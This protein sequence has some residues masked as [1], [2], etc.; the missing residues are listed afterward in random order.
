[1]RSHSTA[2]SAPTA[3]RRTVTLGAVLAVLVLAQNLAVYRGV[4]L[5]QVRSFSVGLQESLIPMGRWIDL[6]T[7]AGSTIATPDI[8]ALGYY[9][10]RRILDLGG[11]VTPAMVPYLMREEPEQATANFR[12]ASFARPEYIVDRGPV[13]DDLRRRSRY[14][15]A[16]RP[17]R[18]ASVPN[19]GIARP[20]PAFY[21]LYR[22]NWAVADSL[23]ALSASV[24]RFR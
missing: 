14:A 17:L 20:T 6:H 4:V 21:T 12:F 18:L 10:H 13:P 22:V 24:G 3:Q 16:L 19:L 2:A 5:P 1:M 15:A 9:G 11:L 7:P 23:A 8:G